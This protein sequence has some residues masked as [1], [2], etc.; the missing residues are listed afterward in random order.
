MKTGYNYDG[1]KSLE[2][3]LEENERLIGYRARSYSNTH[4]AYYDF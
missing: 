4:A 1:K 2:V 3:K